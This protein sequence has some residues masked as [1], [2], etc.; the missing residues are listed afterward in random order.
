ML[1]L[2]VDVGDELEIVVDSRVVVLEEIIG[3]VT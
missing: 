1:G 3:N 2:E